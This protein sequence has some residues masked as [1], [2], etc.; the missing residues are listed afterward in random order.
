MPLLRQIAPWTC[1]NCKHG[2]GDECTRTVVPGKILGHGTGMLGGASGVINNCFI[3]PFSEPVE[4]SVNIKST[5]TYSRCSY[6]C[7]SQE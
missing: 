2:D 7:Y 3:D 1:E 4:Q 6:H 5:I